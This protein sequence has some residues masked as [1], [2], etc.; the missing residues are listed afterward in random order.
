MDSRTFYNTV[1]LMRAMQKETA[2]LYKKSRNGE[3]VDEEAMKNVGKQ[4][5]E[6]ERLVDD[7]IERVQ[8]LIEKG[9]VQ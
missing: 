9:Q 4:K 7:E 1:V 8:A 6:F 2:L 3:A 5:R